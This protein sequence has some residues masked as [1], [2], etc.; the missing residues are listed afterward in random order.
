VDWMHIA[1]DSE[2]WQALMSIVVILQVL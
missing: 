2:N 1:Q